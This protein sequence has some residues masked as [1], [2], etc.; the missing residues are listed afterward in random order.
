MGEQ[1]AINHP[2]RQPS[3]QAELPGRNPGI[4]R[5]LPLLLQLPLPLEN[6]PRELLEPGSSV[7]S[8]QAPLLAARTAARGCREHC[9]SPGQSLA[10]T[11]LCR[12][13]GV[14]GTVYQFFGHR[15][16]TGDP[17]EH[18]CAP[19]STQGGCGMRHGT[20]R[21][22][23]RTRGCARHGSRWPRGG[24]EAPCG[25]PRASSARR[26]SLEHPRVQRC[27][28]PQNTGRGSRFSP[29]RPASPSRSSPW[30]L[31]S[32][33]QISP[34]LHIFHR[35][36]SWKTPPVPK[37]QGRS[38]PSSCLLPSSSSSSSPTRWGCYK[39]LSPEAHPT[40]PQPPRPAPDPV[41]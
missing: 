6:L 27:R 22:C 20:A 29:Q 33:V 19:P 12:G 39:E 25:S 21:G 1:G 35:R 34:R 31:P 23:V 32:P 17:P 28:V 30:P 9:A 36:R 14:P 18:P 15:S 40:T 16:C 10:P 38:E 8:C 41:N 37:G 13:R 2:A 5:L 4:S 3:D 26:G 11:R 24:P 7:P